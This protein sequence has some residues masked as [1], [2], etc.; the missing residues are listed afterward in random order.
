M[1]RAVIADI[2]GNCR[3]L[4]AVFADRDNQQN[5]PLFGGPTCRVIEDEQVIDNSTRLIWKRRLTPYPLSRVEALDYID[6]LK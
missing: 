2:H 3:A 1:R 5:R 6:Q 4:E